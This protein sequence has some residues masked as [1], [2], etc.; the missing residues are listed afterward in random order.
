MGNRIYG[1]DDCQLVCPWNKF[2]QRSTLPDFDARQDL[3]GSGLARLFHWSESEFL[4]RTEGSPLRRIGHARWL[5]NIAV[6][7]GNALRST[8][9][10]ADQATL[11]SALQR[12]AE[13]PDALVREHVQWALA[14]HPPSAAP[15]KAPT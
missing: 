1:C 6:A 7:L 14:Q 4:Q 3:E 9:D 12:H 2:A 8:P 10:A 5:R 11:R 13:H 15:R